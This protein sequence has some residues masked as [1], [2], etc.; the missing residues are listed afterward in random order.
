MMRPSPRTFPVTM[1]IDLKR[2]ERRL[3][4]LLVG[5]LCLAAWRAP[6]A[7]AADDGIGLSLSPGLTAGEV[8]LDWTGGLAP[9][10]VY[11]AATPSGVIDPLHKIGDTS[12][13]AW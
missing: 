12:G 6:A 9:F 10:Q 8:R 3:R 13:H 1:R 5:L 2:S 7:L 4:G 11:R